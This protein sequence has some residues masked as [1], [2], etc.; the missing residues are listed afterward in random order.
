VAVDAVMTANAPKMATATPIAW[1]HQTPL[2]TRKLRMR[3]EA[4][5]A[6]KAANPANAARVTAMAAT[7][8]NAVAAASAANA[9]MQRLRPPQHKVK[10]AKRSST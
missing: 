3:R 7:V 2:E 5:R 4:N 9:L 1:L 8:A 6:K 10:N